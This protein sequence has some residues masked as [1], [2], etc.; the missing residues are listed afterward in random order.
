MPQLQSTNLIVLPYPDLDESWDTISRHPVT[1]VTAVTVFSCSNC[2]ILDAVRR[3]RTAA[4]SRPG[5]IWTALD[6][7][8]VTVSHVVTVV[9][10]CKKSGPAIRR[11]LWAS[12]ASKPLIV[13]AA[14]KASSI[15]DVESPTQNISKHVS[16]RR[17]AG[18]PMFSTSVTCSQEH[19][20]LKISWVIEDLRQTPKNTTHYK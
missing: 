4:F 10:S 20:S 16:P 12:P 6:R 19:H 2:F 3:S 8:H 7:R 15:C 1:A 13:F 18:V 11:T 14:S 17:K 9:T 5:Q